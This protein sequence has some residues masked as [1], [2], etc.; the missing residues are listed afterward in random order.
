[1]KLTFRDEREDWV[2]ILEL[3][4]EHQM[5]AQ[6]SKIQSDDDLFDELENPSILV[7]QTDLSGKR[8]ADTMDYLEQIGLIENTPAP[9]SLT[10][11]GFQVAHQIKTERQRQITNILLVGLTAILVVL[12]VALVV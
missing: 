3:M 4:Y 12:T 10:Q 7:K 2:V 1:M 11:E 5:A 8:I 6:P 9:L